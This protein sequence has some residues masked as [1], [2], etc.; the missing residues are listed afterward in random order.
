M[1]KLW[2]LVLLF[3]ALPAHADRGPLAAALTFH[4]I[5]YLQTLS[6]ATDPR[7][8]ETNPI[9]GEH[10]SKAAVTQYFA[11][12]GLAMY[13]AHALLPEQVAK[14]STYVWLAVGVGAT[15][16]NHSIGVRIRF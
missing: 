11:A 14:Y 2:L 6:I 12:T 10:P 13:A 15:A 1:K 3:L 4:T 9:L 8:K 7:F 16:H 5:D